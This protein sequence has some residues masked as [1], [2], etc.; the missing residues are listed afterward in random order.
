[1]GAGRRTE[2][3][4]GATVGLAKGK[5]SLR[6]PCAGEC[7]VNEVLP[8]HQGIKVLVEVRARWNKRSIQ[9]GTTAF[10][11]RS[12]TSCSTRQ[13]LQVYVEPRVPSNSILNKSTFA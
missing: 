10:C 11:K 3:E 5:A 4:R 9:I 6:D 12:T 1:M 7:R 8:R 2:N 13:E